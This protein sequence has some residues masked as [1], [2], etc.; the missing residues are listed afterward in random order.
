L[1]VVL[2]SNGRKVYPLPQSLSWR[3]FIRPDVENARVHAVA[4]HCE[5]GKVSE[6]RYIL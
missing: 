1:E 4:E 3:S 2:N 6:V 5:E